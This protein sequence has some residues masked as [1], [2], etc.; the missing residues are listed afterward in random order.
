MFG[1]FIGLPYYYGFMIKWTANNPIA[2]FNLQ[3]TGYHHN[4]VFMT[5]V[6]GLIMDMKTKL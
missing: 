6:F 3:L 1:Y 2:L 5:M 4:F